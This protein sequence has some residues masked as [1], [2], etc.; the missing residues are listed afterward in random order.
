MVIV[1]EGERLIPPRSRPEASRSAYAERWARAVNRD[2]GFLRVGQ[3]VE[4]K[5]R[6]AQ[7]CDTVLRRRG[8]NR[9]APAVAQRAWAFPFTRHGTVPGK[10]I[11]AS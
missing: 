6:L 2:V 1:P 4:L 3:P 11:A 5:P 8:A 9:T 10:L 7:E